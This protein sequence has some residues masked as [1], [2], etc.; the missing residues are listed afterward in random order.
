[1]WMMLFLLLPLAALV[2]LSWHIWVMLP[3]AGWLKFLVIALGVVS[4]ALLFLTF[5]RAFDG[6]PLWVARMGYEVGTSSLIVL[7]YLVMLFLVLDLGRL[8]RLV[9]R[10]YLYH[11]GYRIIKIFL[12]VSKDEQKKRFLERIDKAKKE[13]ET[14]TVTEPEVQTEEES[15]TQP[16]PE[17]EAST[18]SPEAQ[19]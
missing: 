8:V 15:T 6:L 2:Y 16:A 17:P 12:N 10:T 4:F 13:I 19:N 7:L 9:P 3:V 5:R 1:M 18:T 11:N 14:T